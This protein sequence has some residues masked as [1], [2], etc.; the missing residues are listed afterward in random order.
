MAVQAAQRKSNGRMDVGAARQF[1]LDHFRAHAI[2][3]ELKPTRIYEVVEW[4]ST[5]LKI[6]TRNG[7]GRWVQT[8]FADLV[9]CKSL[10][11]GEFRRVDL[12]WGVDRKNHDPE[13][14]SRFSTGA[15]ADDDS[16]SAPIPGPKFLPNGDPMPVD[17]FISRR[18]GPLHRS[19]KEKAS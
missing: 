16:F 12:I 11:Y 19:R 4:S 8:L 10:K 3:G 7:N 2:K 15:A 9:T 13:F 18:L 5:K 6:S 1:L 17:A 14:S